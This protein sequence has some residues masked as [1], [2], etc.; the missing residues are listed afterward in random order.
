VI[1]A[2][3][4]DAGKAVKQKEQNKTGRIILPVFIF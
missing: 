4:Q 3:S 2:R 1:T